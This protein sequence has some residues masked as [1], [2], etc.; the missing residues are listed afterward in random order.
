MRSLEN[1]RHTL[2]S[3]RI[4]PSKVRANRVRVL[5]FSHGATLEL[6]CEPISISALD[7]GKEPIRDRLSTLSQPLEKP[8]RRG[9]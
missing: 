1:S 5:D 6:W 2:F 4:D 3:D 7:A 8:T 9:Y